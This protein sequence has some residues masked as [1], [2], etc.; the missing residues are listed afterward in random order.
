MKFTV[1]QNISC[2]TGVEQSLES[3]KKV[4]PHKVLS[5]EV[6]ALRSFPLPVSIL[7]MRLYFTR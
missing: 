5:Y 1:E 6:E 2:R 4:G 7:Y 3:P